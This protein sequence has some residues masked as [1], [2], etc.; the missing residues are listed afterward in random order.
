M[1]KIWLILLVVSATLTGCT[2]KNTTTNDATNMGNASIVDVDS[3][4]SKTPEERESKWQEFVQQ[5]M[6]EQYED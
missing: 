6:M 5:K 3:A 4:G 2:A 1:K